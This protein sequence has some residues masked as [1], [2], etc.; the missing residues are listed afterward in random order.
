M[1]RRDGL[2]RSNSRVPGS[3]ARAAGTK[4]GAQ[5]QPSVLSVAMRLLFV[6]FVLVVNER[7]P[8]Q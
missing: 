5:N 7:F 2:R 4:I 6:G 8:S 1:G 3:R